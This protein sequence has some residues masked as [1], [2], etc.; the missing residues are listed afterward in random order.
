MAISCFSS[1]TMS[2]T[3]ASSFFPILSSWRSNTCCIY[4]QVIFLG[5]F[6]N[7]FGIVFT[8]KIQRVDSLTCSNFV[9]ILHRAKFLWLARL[10]AMTKPSGGVRP[11]AV[12]ETLYWLTSYVLCFQF[13]ETFVTHFSPHQ[14]GVATKG[15]YEVVIHSIRCILDLHPDLIV[16]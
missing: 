9:F 14:F 2:Q 11:I 3:R 5:W 15:G 1:K 4:L 16:L 8:L 7:T 13:H 10:L 12:E 6:L